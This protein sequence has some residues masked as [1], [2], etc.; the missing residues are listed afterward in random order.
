VDANPSAPIVS[1]PAP[2]TAIYAPHPLAYF[3]AHDWPRPAPCQYGIYA[4]CAG[5]ARDYA[6]CTS[7]PLPPDAI[8]AIRAG[9]WLCPSCC[10]EAGDAG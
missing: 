9:V 1:A 2:V 6:P 10:Q 7:T 8:D 5:C 3:C 4:R